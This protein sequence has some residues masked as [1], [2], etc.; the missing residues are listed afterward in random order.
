LASGNLRL[1]WLEVDGR[2]VAVEYQVLGDRSVYAYQSGIDP[3]A[4]DHEPG[5]LITMATLKM[6]IAEGRRAFDF[7]RGDELYKAHWRATPRATQDIRLI[8]DARAA[9]LRHQVWLAGSSLKD[10]LRDGLT[11]SGVALS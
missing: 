11:R 9:R 7:L 10:W 3:D 2:P 6:A 5:R 8:P 1:V 4:L